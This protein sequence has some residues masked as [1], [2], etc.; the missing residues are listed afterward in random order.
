MSGLYAV[1]EGLTSV[2]QELSALV[3]NAAA[4]AGNTQ[5]RGEAHLSIESNV[6]VVPKIDPATLADTGGRAGGI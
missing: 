2:R 1:E 3:M 5:G 6:T 4:T